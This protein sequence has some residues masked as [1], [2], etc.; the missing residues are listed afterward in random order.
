[1]EYT[2]EMRSSDFHWFLD[3]YNELFEQHGK[4]FFVIQNKLLLGVYNDFLKAIEETSKGHELGTF[5]VQ[6][7]DG[8]PN[9]YSSSVV[10]PWIIN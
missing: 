5:I 3:N 8:T 7:C 6:K 9:A 2:D 4:G 10:T 1:M